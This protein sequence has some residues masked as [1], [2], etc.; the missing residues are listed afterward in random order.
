MSRVVFH[1][2]PSG[3]VAS[4]PPGIL[5][6]DDEDLLLSL[7]EV[8][9]RRQ[10]FNVFTASSGQDALAIYQANQQSIDM[11]LLDVRMPGMD[12]PTTLQALRQ[13]NPQLRC[14]FMSGELGS[15]KIDDLLALGAERVFL[16]PFALTQVAA[17]LWNLVHSTP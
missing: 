9:L 6:V 16:K 17:E 15:I 4:Q 11:A 14:C 1:L 2:S 10:G 7:M 13:I 3:S 5:V 12:G 8:V